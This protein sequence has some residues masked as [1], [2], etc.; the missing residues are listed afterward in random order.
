MTNR[1]DYD[2]VIVGGGAAG[3]SAVQTAVETAPSLSVALMSD[4]A[5]L[6]YKRTKIS[7]TFADGFEPNQ[8]AVLPETW[9]SDHG[10]DLYVGST[11]DEL[12]VDAGA[13][14]LRRDGRASTT[15]LSWKRLIL[16]TGA[17]PPAAARR[18]VTEA[19]HAFH[20]NDIADI[21]ALRAQAL[22]GI[23]SG[24]SR[25]LVV[26]NGVMGIEVA[27]D[28]HKLG[29][30]VTVVGRETL[31][32]PRDLDRHAGEALRRICEEHGME[33]L[34]VDEEEAVRA[35]RAA[36][37]V[38]AVAVGLVPRTDLAERAGLR[39]SRAVEVDEYLL[40]SS[41]AVYAAG[42][43]AQLPDGRVT[44][45]WRDAMRQGEIAGVNAAA[46]LT[47]PKAELRPYRYRP[48]RLK[49]KIFGNHFFS[50][51]RPAPEDVDAYEERVYQDGP[52]YVHL[53][54]RDGRVH[55]A[56]VMNDPD[57]HDAYMEAIN[58]RWP[59]ERFEAEFGLE[60]ARV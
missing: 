56:V 33:F 19:A 50:L 15:T 52:R 38:V 39:I 14:R 37:H 9:Y 44:H 59:V 53:Y 51:R 2:I 45:L 3:T 57:N 29:C 16:A 58:D 1:K 11:V 47:S 49:T 6:P 17:S 10:V 42:D 5:R 30:R 41:A 12:D 20:T 26:G 8:W 25:A 4:E 22:R 40:S 55:G 13:L 24:N 46:E 43:C 21:E 36:A 35:A 60:R 27:H 31:P 28:L 48:F 54:T 23:E 34:Q 7:K 32:L 18:L